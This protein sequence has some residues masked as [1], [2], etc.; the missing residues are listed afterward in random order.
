MSG[1]PQAYSCLLDGRLC[2]ATVRA[3]VAIAIAFARAGRRVALVDLDVRRPS[4]HF[5][6]LSTIVTGSGMWSPI[7]RTSS[8]RSRCRL[9]QYHS[10]GTSGPLRPQLVEWH[11]VPLYLPPGA[12]D[13]S[14]QLSRDEPRLHPHRRHAQRRLRLWSRLRQL[15][16][17]LRDEVAAGTATCVAPHRRC[18]A[19]QGSVPASSLARNFPRNGL[20]AHRR[21]RSRS[22]AAKRPRTSGQPPARLDPQKC[23]FA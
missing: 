19:S 9:H 20:D 11:R 8:S 23:K 21:S 18:A 17:W 13:G 15:L 22:T 14:G 5:F 2:A 12:L 6:F 10:R 16:L 7:A 3:N 4:S 1:A